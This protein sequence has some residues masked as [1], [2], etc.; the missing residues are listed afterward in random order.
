MLD[1]VPQMFSFYQGRRHWGYLGEAGTPRLAKCP[2]RHPQLSYGFNINP[3]LRV[4]VLA[5]SY[6]SLAVAGPVLFF[7]AMPLPFIHAYLLL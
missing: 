7:V 4:P 3:G 5:P 6:A 2:L 1:M